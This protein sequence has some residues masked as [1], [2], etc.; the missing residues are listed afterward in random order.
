MFQ[1]SQN[2]YKDYDYSE[3]VD[4]ID[5]SLNS[6][7]VYVDSLAKNDNTRFVWIVAVKVVAVT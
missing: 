5:S 7:K 3:A 4:I 1:E 6:M 2:Y